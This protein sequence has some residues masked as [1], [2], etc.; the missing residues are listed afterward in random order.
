MA[1]NALLGGPFNLTNDES[2]NRYV[3]YVPVNRHLMMAIHDF[4]YRGDAMI[5][6][7]NAIRAD[8]ALGRGFYLEWAEKEEIL[9]T[10]AHDYTSAIQAKL[11]KAVQ[12]FEMFGFVAFVVP[13][14]TARE[15]I[16]RQT[17]Q[18]TLTPEEIATRR[19]EECTRKIFSILN[20]KKS[21]RDND[22]AA[23]SAQEQHRVNVG[24]DPRAEA[25]RKRTSA[26]RAREQKFYN[27][28]ALTASDSRIDFVKR[29]FDE[30][31]R[32]SREQRE[33]Q[34]SIMDMLVQ[35]E[36]VQI[37]DVDAG[38]FYL[39]I[40]DLRHTKRLVWLPNS[41]ASNV[42]S[43]MG[44][45]T[46]KFVDYDHNVH[47]CEWPGREVTR[48]GIIQTDFVELL[49]LREML[50]ECE[51]NAM[52]ANFQSSH[53]T[54][55]IQQ[56]RAPSKVDATELPEENLYGMT[57]VEQAFNVDAMS[58][59]E[60]EKHYTNMRDSV[61]LDMVVAL[62][63]DE[64]LQKRAMQVAKGHARATRATRGGLSVAD[65][66]TTMFEK[67]GI[68][69]LPNGLTLGGVVQP[70]LLVDMKELRAVYERQ[71]SIALGVPL[72]YL[73]GEQAGSSA[74]NQTQRAAGQ[75]ST[76][77]SATTTE[78]MMRT[79]IMSYREKA[80][81]FLETMYDALFHTADNE[82]LIERLAGTMS[83]RKK[84][85]EARDALVRALSQTYDVVSD[86][87]ALDHNL[88]SILSEAAR[89]CATESELR[90]VVQ[91]QHRLKLKFVKAPFVETADIQMMFQMGALS[92]AEMVNIL[93]AQNGLE[94]IEEDEIARI[95]D[96]NLVYTQAQVAAQ[97][98]PPDPGSTTTV[99]KIGQEQVKAEG[100]HVTKS[101]AAGEAGKDAK[102]KTSGGGGGGGG[103]QKQEQEAGNKQATNK[104]ETERIV[105]TIEYG[106]RESISVAEKRRQEEQQRKK[107][108]A[109][110]SK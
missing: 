33:R 99:E 97:T 37:L 64:Q 14:V 91:M 36:D 90:R 105:T 66:R 47:V 18:R 32:V 24:T 13:N 101:K 98:P 40:D 9:P 63:H 106:E 26:L 68:M 109:R 78:Q 82:M 3:Y 31:E 54:P 10:E 89:L 39:Q 49:R 50:R 55:F 85:N 48:E 25:Q 95:F 58:A 81:F 21:R 45:G 16:D 60:R 70:S 41:R 83:A 35:L 62:A 100:Q 28:N 6:R 96:D 102:G 59:T 72:S 56:S 23:A 51:D 84:A 52:D 71:L 61:M 94:K 42:N 67:S 27:G 75:G 73:C 22:T 15:E 69:H 29:E 12:W 107:K 108:K 4:Y 43:G 88:S 93:R 104:S 46:L 77:H 5:S 30:A 19:I 1:H 8:Q 74:R 44:S 86:T 17:E 87:A 53:P 65:L 76:S 20:E 38:Q 34:M 7:A 92:R 110:K 79:T 11:E 80:A 57:N 103:A 2:S